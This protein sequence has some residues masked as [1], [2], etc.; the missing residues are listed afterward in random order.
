MG[1]VYNINEVKNLSKWETWGYTRGFTN[2]GI[3]PWLTGTKAA[4][5]Y[6]TKWNK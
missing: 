5:E 4:Y 2:I 3:N 1:Q 6:K